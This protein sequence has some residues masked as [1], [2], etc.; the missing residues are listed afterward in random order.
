MRGRLLTLLLTTAMV[1]Q[2]AALAASGISTLAGAC[3]HESTPTETADC[4]PD[5]THQSCCEITCLA[6][7]GV[8]VQATA[9]SASYAGHA[10]FAEPTTLESL[11]QSPP[12]PP[13]IAST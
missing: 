3:N 11:I 8:T 7:P 1:F 4:C 9:A 6:A 12:T 5:D 13:P 10:S 2:G